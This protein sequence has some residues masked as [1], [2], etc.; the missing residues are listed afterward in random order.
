MIVIVSTR[1]LGFPSIGGKST[2][3]KATEPE[4]ELQQQ[5]QGTPVQQLQKQI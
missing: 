2:A 5:T 1:K 4:L 3:W